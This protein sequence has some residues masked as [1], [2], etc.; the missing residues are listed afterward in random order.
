MTNNQ[1]KIINFNYIM[2][3]KMNLAREVGERVKLLRK[4]KGIT[5][6][7]LAWLCEKD[8]QA[9][10]LVENGKTN[11]TIYTLY[12]ICYNLEIEMKEIF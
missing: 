4:G 10:E 2:K 7:K 8:P 9:V 3:N 5:Q 1:I 11:P 12:I 6:S